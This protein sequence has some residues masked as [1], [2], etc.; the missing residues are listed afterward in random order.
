MKFLI[1]LTLFFTVSTAYANESTLH[2]LLIKLMGDAFHSGCVS[3]ALYVEGT[4]NL[5]EDAKTACDDMS[6]NYQEAVKEA[7]EKGKLKP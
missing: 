5:S 3:H 7:L 1:V 4:N 2:L 6:K